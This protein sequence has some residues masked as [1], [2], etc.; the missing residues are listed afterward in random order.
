[1]LGAAWTALN[2]AIWSGRGTG[3]GAASPARENA[4]ETLE[5]RDDDRLLLLRPPASPT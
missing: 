4:A 2:A 5:N 3:S 1:M